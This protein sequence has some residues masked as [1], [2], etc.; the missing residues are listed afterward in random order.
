MRVIKEMLNGNPETRGM[1]LLLSPQGHSADTFEVSVVPI[2]SVDVRNSKS[3]EYLAQFDVV[4]ARNQQNEAKA[5]L[6]IMLDIN[7]RLITLPFLNTRTSC[8][9]NNYINQDKN[10]LI[11]R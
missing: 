2:R 3:G 5:R 6:I 8:H 11:P 10:T 1:H 4:F 9:T 7:I